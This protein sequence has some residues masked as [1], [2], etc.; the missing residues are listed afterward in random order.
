[1]SVL[2][3]EAAYSFDMRLLDLSNLW[4]GPVLGQSSA[5]ITFDKGHGDSVRFLTG[6]VDYYQLDQPRSGTILGIF[7]FGQGQPAFSITGLKIAATDFY[8]WAHAHDNI[9][10]MSAAFGGDDTL[11]GGD[12]GDYLTGLGGHDVVMGGA[13]ADTLIGGEGNDHLYGQS[14]NGGPD[15]AD[16][17]SGGN[18][19]DYLQGNAGNDTLDG[20]A[21]SDRLIGGSGNDLI[22]GG[23]GNDSAN[24][25]LGDDT[26]QGGDGNDSLRGGQGND[27]IDGGIGDNVM[28]GDLGNDTIYGG[29]GDDT[30]TGGA[31]AD[32]FKFENVLLTMYSNHADVITDYESGTD[33]LALSFGFAPGEVHD[34]GTPTNDAVWFM[35]GVATNLLVNSGRGADIAVFHEHGDTYVL[36]T[37]GGGTSLTFDH[38]VILRGEHTI[39]AADFV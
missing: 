25:N 5:L 9:A 6:E 33:H 16:S 17:L 29:E 36:W 19:S 27:W 11:T 8:N 13:G 31:G 15:G 21:G 14:P 4:G 10:A 3:S 38:A 23:A 20:G 32:V 7:Y 39:T 18:G 26:I 30:M 35:K 2:T 24:G 34:Y 12:L 28:N 22:V 37:T 1:M